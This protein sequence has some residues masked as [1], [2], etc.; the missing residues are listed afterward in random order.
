MVNVTV[1]TYALRPLYFVVRDAPKL[2]P[3]QESLI[4]QAE[5]GTY[6]GNLASVMSL[7]YTHLLHAGMNRR[8][9][10][11]VAMQFLKK[12]QEDLVFLQRNYQITKKSKE[13]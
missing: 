9:A 1:R 5:N 10:G 4:F 3:R 2:N 8:T 13:L 7:I 6:F 11:K 12:S